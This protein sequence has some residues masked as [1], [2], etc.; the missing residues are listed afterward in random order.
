MS[1]FQQTVNYIKLHDT[2]NKMKT[3]FCWLQAI[4]SQ[5]SINLNLTS[6]TVSG[7]HM[8][9]CNTLKAFKIGYPTVLC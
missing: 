8:K 1:S 5:I 9:K 6:E 3:C 4:P 7:I 2:D